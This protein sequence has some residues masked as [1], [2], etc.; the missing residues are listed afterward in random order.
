MALFQDSLDI[1]AGELMAR[2]MGRIPH[3]EELGI[4]AES[5]A[6]PRLTMRLPYRDNLVVDAETGILHGGAVTTLVDTAAGL[7]AMAAVRPAHS[8]ATLDLRLDYLRPGLRGQDILCTAEVYRATRTIVFV[9]AHALQADDE[10]EIASALGTFMIIA[11]PKAE[12]A[13]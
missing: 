2:I 11:R 3:C 10:R 9:R 12:A 13:P 4:V 6:P 1:P 7:L 8:V 5:F